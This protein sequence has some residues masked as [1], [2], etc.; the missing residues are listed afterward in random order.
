[1]LAGFAFRLVPGIVRAAAAA[2][3][4][5]RLAAETAFA[6]IAD[7]F[8]PGI[9]PPAFLAEPDAATNHNE[10]SVTSALQPGC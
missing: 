3:P 4:A 6:P 7:R 1:M 9:F 10:S 2:D 5:M 8:L